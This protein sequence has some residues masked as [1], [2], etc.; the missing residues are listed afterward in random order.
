ML[1]SHVGVG[2]LVRLI[3]LRRKPKKTEESSLS[4]DKTVESYVASLCMWDNDCCKGTRHLR[5]FF[6]RTSKFWSIQFTKCPE[7]QN[8]SRMRRFLAIFLRLLTIWI[9]FR[10]H[11]HFLPSWNIVQSLG[12]LD[13]YYFKIIEYILMRYGAGKGRGTHIQKNYCVL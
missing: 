3:R 8:I 10:T 12:S 13:Y 2:Q 11:I 5:Y 7:H 4:D 6:M 1:L 9:S